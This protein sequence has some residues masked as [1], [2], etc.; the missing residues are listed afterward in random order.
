[1]D[2][3][4]LNFYQYL[5]CEELICD[6]EVRFVA[7]GLTAGGSLKPIKYQN[8][9][10]YLNTFF[11][12]HGILRNMQVRYSVEQIKKLRPEIK[13]VIDKYQRISDKKF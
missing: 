8:G 12:S 10:Y 3:C 2:K 9:I 6:K 13:N 1:L 11:A 4:K 5:N 7:T